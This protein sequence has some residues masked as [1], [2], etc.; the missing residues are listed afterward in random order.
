MKN[1]YGFGKKI[2]IDSINITSINEFYE[3]DFNNLNRKNYE[4]DEKNF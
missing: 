1:K 3:E 2:F 4:L